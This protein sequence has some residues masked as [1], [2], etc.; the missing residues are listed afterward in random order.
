MCRETRA[1]VCV[2]TLQGIVPWLRRVF[3]ERCAKHVCYSACGAQTINVQNITSLAATSNKIYALSSSG[4]IY[5]VASARALQQSRP[6]SQN[7]TDGSSQGSSWWDTFG[8]GRI[9]RAFAQDPGVDC[10]K[11][12]VNGDGL[13]KGERYVKPL[14]MILAHPDRLVSLLSRC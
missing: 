2:R 5:V 10:V 6:S 11:L 9:S 1:V 14:A 4:D 12:G 8:L 3:E 13:K 7:G